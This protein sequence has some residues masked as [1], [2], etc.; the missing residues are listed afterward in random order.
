MKNICVFC[1]SRM[2][3]QPIY[4]EVTRALAKSLVECGFNLVYGGSNIGLMGLLADHVM[5]QGGNVIGVMPQFLADQEVAHT[6]LSQIYLVNS[7]HERKQKMSELAD[8]FITLPGGIGTFEEFLEI[9]T[10]AQL[11]LHQKPVSLLNTHGYYDLLLQFFNHAISQGFFRRE[12]RDLILVE[13][14]PETLCKKLSQYPSYET[15]F[16][17]YKT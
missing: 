17:K 3:N 12:T 9:T 1:G 2:G 11:G 10:W 6:H 5:I 16:D 4:Q 14:D 13:N 15:G 7:M 8:A